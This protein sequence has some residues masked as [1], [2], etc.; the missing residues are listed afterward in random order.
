MEQRGVRGALGR[1]ARERRDNRRRSSLRSRA[2]LQ[3]AAA[4]LMAAG[5]EVTHVTSWLWRCFFHVQPM[6]IIA[7]R[8]ASHDAPENTLAS[9]RLAWEQGADGLECDV[10][11]TRDGQLVVIHD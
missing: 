6:D 3:P 4:R 11:L 1:P 7:H 8:G 10:H 9:A 5:E 2:G